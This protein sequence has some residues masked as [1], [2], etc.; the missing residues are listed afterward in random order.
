[1]SLPFKIHYRISKFTPSLSLRPPP[2]PPHQLSRLSHFSSLLP[3]FLS[4]VIFFFFVWVNWCNYN[5]VLTLLG[6][7]VHTEVIKVL[8]RVE[9][10]PPLPHTLSTS[11]FLHPSGL[12]PVF[13]L[14]TPLPS[15][16]FMLLISSVLLF[17]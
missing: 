3:L 10:T 12:S 1:M 14:L 13:L 5:V 7:N 15:P 11:S 6:F 17:P 8:G 16:R 2:Q 4:V 9:T